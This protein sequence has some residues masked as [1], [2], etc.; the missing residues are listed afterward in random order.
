MTPPDR[1]ALAGNAPTGRASGVVNKFIE[2][3]ELGNS[4][5]REFRT[6]AAD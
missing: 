4:V 1:A 5:V 3:G 2:D 6:T